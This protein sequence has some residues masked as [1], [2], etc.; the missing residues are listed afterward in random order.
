MPYREQVHSDAILSNVALQYSQDM[1]IASQA[2]PIVSV[3]K[4]SDKYFKFYL[5]DALNF[6]ARTLRGD[7]AESAETTWDVTTG[8]YQCEEYALKD[9]VTD[10]ARKNADSPIDM[11][12]DTTRFLTG[13]LLLDYEYR[14]ATAV[15]NTTTFTDHHSALTSDDMWDVYTAAG[16]DSDPIA[17]IETA[18]DSVLKN[19][20]KPANTIIMGYEVF[21]KVVHHPSILARI[22]YGGTP[23]DPAT[24]TPNALAQVFN[25]SQ[26]LVGR[27]VY[28]SA[29]EGATA[30]PAYV[31]GKY[32]M[33]AYIENPVP[34]KGVTLGATFQSQPFQVEKW[35]ESKRK[36]D[37][38][39]V[40]MVEDEV[41]IAEGAG[42][43]LS[44]VVS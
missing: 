11:D 30:T 10:R 28:N 17:D 6:P 21:K 25:V 16:A 24:V 33:T 37:M 1:F 41:I 31:W 22:Q 7:G 15:F 20:L 32:V 18:K 13:Q 42:Y 27:A 40:S 14:V 5:K 44:T 2:L 8:T 4:E 9:I 39:E 26:V 36:G 19:S 43:L 12:I 38:V 23:A 35:R 29:V 3:N 34:R